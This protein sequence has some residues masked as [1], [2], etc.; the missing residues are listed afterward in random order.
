MNIGTATRRS[1]LIAAASAIVLLAGCGSSDEPSAQQPS[2]TPATSASGSPSASGTVVTVTETDFALALSQTTFTPGTYTF[3]AENNGNTTHALEIEG[4]GIEEQETNDLS[5]GDSGQLTVD[6]QAG[7]YELY[8]PVDGHK[9]RGM[10]TEITV[11]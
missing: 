5:P 6:L 7:T 1:G 3:V 9:D 4:P 8:C 2:S 10:K 11:A